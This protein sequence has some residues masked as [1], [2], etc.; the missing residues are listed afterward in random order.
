MFPPQIYCVSH[1]VPDGVDPYSGSP[2]KALRSLYMHPFI[3]TV[4]IT[5]AATHLWSVA[6][7]E[8]VHVVT[9]EP[10]LPADTAAVGSVVAQISS[11]FLLLV[12]VTRFSIDED[13]QDM[14]SVLRLYHLET[15]AMVQDICLPR[16]VSFKQHSDLVAAMVRRPDSTAEIVLY[17]LVLQR[18][19]EVKQ[20]SCNDHGVAFTLSMLQIHDDDALLAA[21]STSSSEPLALTL[22]SSGDGPITTMLPPPDQRAD[23]WE[24]QQSQS[25]PGSRVALSVWEADSGN[26]WQF[27]EHTI[28]VLQI[29]SLCMDWST[30]LPFEP[31][32]ISCHPS[33]G[34]MVAVSAPEREGAEVFVH[35]AFLNLENGAVIREESIFCGGERPVVVGCSSTGLLVMVTYRGSIVIEPLEDILQKGFQVREGK[36][37]ECNVPVDPTA[38]YGGDMERILDEDI[39]PESCWVHSAYIAPD[40][41][42]LVHIVPDGVDVT[43]YEGPGSAFKALRSTYTHRYLVTVDIAGLTSHLWSVGAEGP[44]QMATMTPSLPGNLTRNGNMVGRM[45]S[46]PVLVVGASRFDLD[47]DEE[48]EWSVLRLYDLETGKLAQDVQLPRMKDWM[49]QG[50]Y[51]AVTIRSCSDDTYQVVVLLRLICGTLREVSRFRTAPEPENFLLRAVDDET[52]L[53]GLSIDYALSDN[54]DLT[55]TM[56]SPGSALNSI[57]LSAIG[58]PSDW[59]RIEAVEDLPLNPG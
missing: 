8:M 31:G 21:R 25:I 26:D 14:W 24:V 43:V 45:D 54:N 59:L 16:V 30:H 44:V 18:L 41:C 19:E 46:A 39:P 32:S 57:V 10:S 15:G 47:M 40:A 3:V 52:I 29:P 35:V 1:T 22:F 50:D 23:C 11:S 6:S 37:L 55:L 34:V 2:A 48:D 42:R 4:D 53:M 5:G 9:L 36:A 20:W 13:T 28:H 51:M 27:A 58:G 7:G 12:A 17:R 56:R 49:H 33:L 38:F